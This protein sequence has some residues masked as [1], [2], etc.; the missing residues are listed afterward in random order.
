MTFNVY[1]W[2]RIEQADADAERVVRS[3]MARLACRTGVAGR[4]MKK[5]GEPGLWM[6]AYEGIADPDAFNLRLGQLVDEFDLEMFVADCRHT[7][8]FET[9]LAVSAAC[10]SA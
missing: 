7:E 5:W 6:E 2:Y 1:V 10:K 9:D 3:M 4:L 8:C